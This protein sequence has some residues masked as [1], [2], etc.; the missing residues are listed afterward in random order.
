MMMMMS[1][2]ITDSVLRVTI[3][4]AWKN[5]LSCVN[6]CMFIQSVKLNECV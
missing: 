2:F 4:Q 5:Q 1:V 6:V 3:Q